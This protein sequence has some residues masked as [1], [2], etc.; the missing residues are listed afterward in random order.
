MT[1]VVA[2]IDAI[3][4]IEQLLYKEASL[5]DRPDLDSWLELYTEDGTYW[6]P[7][8]DGYYVINRYYGPTPRLN[9]N[10]V[11]DILFKGTKL[12]STFTATK[13]Q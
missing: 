12:E 1:T 4:D 11:H 2:S 7:V 10:T 8:T 9:G 6:M 13:F 3:R 5:L